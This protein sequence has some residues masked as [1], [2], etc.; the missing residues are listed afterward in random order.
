MKKMLMIYPNNFLQGA[1]GT[2][3]R[4]MQLVQIFRE[5]GFEIDYFGFENFSPNSSFRDFKQ[6]NKEK[7]LI[8]KLF[9]Y[10]FQKGYG[11]NQLVERVCHKVRTVQKKDY[12]QDW[13]P[14]GALRMFTDLLKHRHYD[15]V[16]TFYTYLAAFF[17]D[18]KIHAK[19]VYFMEDS[20]FLQQYAWDKDRIKGISLGKL[21]DE[22][23]A[24]I[25]Y[26]DKVCCISNDERIFYEKI[27]GKRMYFLP[28]LMP[29]H[30][31]PVHTPL[32]DRT[33]DVFFI[34]F[35]NTFNVEG[36]QWFLE[37]VYPLLKKDLRILLVGSAT[38]DLKIKYENVD[39]L[40]FVPD[41]DEIYT[42]VKV[43]I[44][45]MFQGTGMKVKVVEAMSKGL[46]VVCNERGVDGMPDKTMCGCL[47][48]QNV[49]EFAG[50]INR[51]IENEEFYTQKS[52]E[53]RK[54]YHQMFDRK[55]YVKL[56]TKLLA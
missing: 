49:T 44:C 25:Q 32:S 52:L 19:K 55:K 24:K 17:K 36:L 45:P 23:I 50:Y 31:V 41:L 21:M 1:M 46:P 35:H 43:V 12:L 10:D 27:T 37:K 5:I 26:F 53:I 7:N 22:E 6:Q 47:V 8:H 40:P 54:Y 34:G 51:L 18:R 16:L 48:T 4:V 15:V 56:L 2:N 42:N 39:I 3:N 28:H 13:V 14:P 29:E 38:N 20:M 11:K 33:W 9:L 30:I